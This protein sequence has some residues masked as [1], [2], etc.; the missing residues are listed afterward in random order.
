MK[1]V[2]NL[3]FITIAALPLYVI[4]CKNFSWCV[5]PIPFTL[6]EILIILTFFSW[7]SWIS[8]SIKKKKESVPGL[9]QRLKNPLILPIGL[10]LFSATISLFYTPD[11]AG[12]LGV[13]KAY[14]IEGFL[15][16]LV[17]LDLSVREK[18]YLWVVKALMVSGVLVAFVSF[19]EALSI[20]LKSD[21]HEALN[22][23]ISSLYE[24]PNA[25]SLYLGPVISL[26]IA[27]LVSQYISS[28]NF[29]FFC[30]SIVSLIS[31]MTAILLS[32]SK[33]GVVGVYAIFS[34]W[35]GWFRIY[36]RYLVVALVFAYFLISIFVFLNVD[37]L[38]PKNKF[39]SGSILNRYCIWQGTKNL[40]AEKPLTGSGLNGFNI[41]YRHFRET[42]ST[43]CLKESYYYPHNLLLT[44][45]SEIGFFGVVAFIWISYLYLRLA[46]Q[47]NDKAFSLGLIGALVY[48][49]IHGLVDVPFF[50][51]DLSILFWILLAVVSVGYKLNQ[52]MKKMRF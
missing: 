11:F 37:N 48:I 36:A 46:S 9:F 43:H 1:I 13:W 28:K 38:I 5:T 8:Y 12:G 3:A 20:T 50:K 10:F 14:F 6:A 18:S 27:A 19:K 44:F 25:V 52:K 17:I 39:P 47:L 45:W 24:F 2:K 42:T 23:R 4:R 41:D 31:M 15:L 21:F 35:L 40:L 32:H 7:V 29:R 22:T 33:G 30:L 49:Y 16:Y 34:V 26:S 51:N